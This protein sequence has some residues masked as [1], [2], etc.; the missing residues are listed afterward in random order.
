MKEGFRIHVSLIV[1]L[2]DS[3]TGKKPE[4]SQLHVSVEGG[5]T[6]I[7][8]KEGYYIF[9]NLDSDIVTVVVTSPE[10][11]QIRK[12]VALSELDEKEPFI[13]IRIQPSRAYA[14]RA[15]A[16]VI[17][18]KAKPLQELLFAAME[19]SV[20]YR[21]MSDCEGKHCKELTIFN[22]RMETLEGRRFLMWQKGIKKYEI[23]HIIKMPNPNMENY[24]LESSLEKSYKKSETRLYPI[25]DC[26]ADENGDYFILIPS[27]SGEK[28]ELVCSWRLGK[29]QENVKLEVASGK[30]NQVSFV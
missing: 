3:F 15:G 9:T 30:E 11:Q 6:P 28:T 8:K 10:Y 13:T 7:R 29:K 27:L 20:F 16:T 23:A 21:L 1:S 14:N 25:Y 18:G 24:I 5:K 2:I 12:R 26:S 4:T 19:D 17:Y 22:P